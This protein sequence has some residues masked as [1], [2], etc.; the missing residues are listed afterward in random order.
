M[1]FISAFEESASLRT[2]RC[3]ACGLRLAVSHCC[4]RFAEAKGAKVGGAKYMTLRVRHVCSVGRLACPDLTSNLTG[5]RKGPC[6]QAGAR[7]FA[8]TLALCPPR[9][10]CARASRARARCIH[11]RM[12]VGWQGA[13]GIVVA[14]T[15]SG[16][17]LLTH[18]DKST[19]DECMELAM[20]KAGAL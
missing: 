6:L 15:G 1:Q 17:L 10:P 9:T 13:N 18:D 12:R 14:K 19:D 5:G 3:F 20:A 8:S 2:T 4:G 11:A 16:V 7:Q